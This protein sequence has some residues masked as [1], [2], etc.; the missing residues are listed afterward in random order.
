MTHR[1]SLLLLP[2]ALLVARCAPPPKPPAVLTLVVTGGAEQ[3]PDPAGKPAP[4]AVR[5]Y[6]LT[7]TAK[8]ERSDWTSLT[9][10]EQATLGQDDAG[11]E[12]VVV[13]P[14][15]TLTRTVE[16]KNGVQ[17]LGVVVLYRDIDHAQ[18]RAVAPV[19]TSG[20]TRLSLTVGKLAVTLKPAQ[21]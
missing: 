9:E 1:R 13:S 21:G 6:Q 3:N 16:L 10:H 4:V 2:A 5:L 14:G 19:A 17:A 12:E 20:P 7:A 18:W 8:F 15:Q 11:S